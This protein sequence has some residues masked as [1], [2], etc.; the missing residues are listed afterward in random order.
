[1][2]MW[3]VFI[4]IEDEIIQSC[5][6][7]WAFHEMMGNTIIDEFMM[8]DEEDSDGDDVIGE[9]HDFSNWKHT[10]WISSFNV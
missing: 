7:A 1:M 5:E 10:F 8:G 4:E 9:W 2:K 6:E 3:F